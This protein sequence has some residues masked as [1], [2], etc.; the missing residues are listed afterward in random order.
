M[1]MGNQNENLLHENLKAKADRYA[2]DPKYQEQFEVVK[3]HFKEYGIRKVQDYDLAALGEQFDAFKNYYGYLKENAGISAD[4]GVLP[5][6]ALDIITASFANSIIPIVASVQNIPEVNGTIYYKKLIATKTRGNVHANDA[7]MQS[8]QAPDVFP[9]SYAG[10]IQ[11]ATLF[12]SVNAQSHYSGTIAS[13]NLP[14]KPREVNI[15][16]DALGIQLI[17]NGNGNLLGI[18]SSGTI[19]YATGD[20]TVDLVANPGVGEVFAVQYATDFENMQYSTN[21]P[22]INLILDSTQVTAQEFVLGAEMGM[23]KS[24]QLKQRFG[25]LP[26]DDLVKDLTDVITAEVGNNIIQQVQAFTPSSGLTWSQTPP[27][28]NISWQDH[29]FEL[30]KKVA[31]V[32]G[33]IYK[34]AGRGIINVIIAGIDACAIM[35]TLPNFKK[36][37]LDGIGPHFFGTLN[38]KVSIVRAPN[39]TNGLSMFLM[40]KGTG[41]FDAPVVY[42]PYMPLFVTGTIPSPDNILK[43][44]GLAAIMAGVKVTVPK[45]MSTLTITA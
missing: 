37:G 2:K 24:Y 39:L 43:K 44:E 1:L 40:Y 15:T 29:R 14:I 11:T 9:N 36:S 20:W 30:L 5:N 18:G 35:E 16:C 13:T 33:Q 8:R 10:S 27:G 32:E 45:F 31:Q 38:D 28:N 12:T 7:I 23:F 26:E 6:V 17:D 19:D 22:K 34:Q 41:Y 21:L 4:L 25:A 42:A 3:D